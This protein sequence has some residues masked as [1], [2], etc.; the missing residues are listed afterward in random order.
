MQ[1]LKVEDYKLMKTLVGMSQEGLR[2]T[3]ATYLENKYPKLIQTKDYLYAEGDIPIALVAHLDTVFA[4]PAKDVFYDREQGVMWSPQGLGAD[5]RAGIFAIIK[6]LQSK[7]R[8]TVI[9]TTDEEKG[10]LGSDKL[11]I[12]FPEAPSKLNYIIQLD[13][14]GT[15][16]CVFYDC[17]NDAFVK[18]VEQFGFI[19]N[20]GSLSDI[21]V[22]CPEWGMA[23][24]NLS[25]GYEG[26]H[27]ET[28]I[29]HV[30]PLLATIEKV[31]VM[32]SQQDIPEFQYIPSQYSWYSMWKKGYGGA[33]IYS[34]PFDDEY[35]C[36]K[37]KKQLTE[38]EV[39]PV[40]D[41]NGKDVY[42][43]GDCCIENIEWC[44]LCKGGYEATEED[45]KS[46][47]HFCPSCKS[48]S[49]KI[50]GT[51]GKRKDV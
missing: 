42:Y 1:N 26:E 3:M 9:L 5:D 48:K 15:N 39:I 27:S 36:C 8:P 14:R 31:K 28:E 49:A 29:L 35:T 21:S 50:K 45:K 16:D 38:Y 23:G 33:G 46:K 17:D 25:V 20:F 2:R 43:C 19:E 11:V 13:R 12:D 34:Y 44:D 37:C 51:G 30:G 32:L 18:Y 40:V 22:I 41:K 6:I 4:K 47:R 24:V 7:Y 10:C